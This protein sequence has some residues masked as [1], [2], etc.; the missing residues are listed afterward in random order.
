VSRRFLGMLVRVP[1]LDLKGIA[2]GGG[3][4]FVDDQA[5]K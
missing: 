1:V 2:A 4:R 5:A 3:N